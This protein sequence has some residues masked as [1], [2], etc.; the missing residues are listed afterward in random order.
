VV[1]LAAAVATADT[2]TTA[3]QDYLLAHLE[4]ALAL[5]PEERRRLR[6]HLHLLLSTPA[7][8][9]GMAARIS[10]LGN[11]EREKIARLCVDVAAADGVIAPSE[12]AVLTKIYKLLA[13]PETR[14]FQDI[15]AATA[16]HAAVEP[17]TVQRA[18]ARTDFGYP[19]P[20]APAP[21]T[22]GKQGF[23]LD[24]A[25]ISAKVAETARVS[26]LLGSI[27][28]D[29]DAPLE[30]LRPEPAADVPLIGNLDAVHS[31][32]LRDLGT[33][34]TWSRTAVE[35]LCAGRGLLTDGAIDVLNDAAYEC[36]GDPVVTGVDPLEIDLD[37]L[38]EMQ[39]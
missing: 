34:P 27:F 25:A 13:L 31:S 32:L 8:L 21:P 7:K 22:G 4:T 18:S 30:Q 26:E 17:V 19:V 35:D 20:P 11:D 5:L 16:T 38:E 10:D 29:D 36:A 15:H 33:S 14:A 6:A 2:S 37:V 28:A 1:R 9:T 12:V 3:E 23:G 24:R 39:R